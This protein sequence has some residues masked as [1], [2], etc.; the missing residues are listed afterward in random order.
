MFGEKL[1]DTGSFPEESARKQK[2][3]NN[4]WGMGARGVDLGSSG[5]SLY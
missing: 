1:F 2:Y 4:S 3:W 5:K